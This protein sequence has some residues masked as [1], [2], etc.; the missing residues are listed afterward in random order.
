[1][2]LKIIFLSI[3]SFFYFSSKA[4]FSSNLPIVKLSISQ[5]IVDSYQQTSLDI[6]DNAS[7][8]NSTT[9]AATFTSNAGVR[10]RGNA[11][12]QAYPKK[13]YSLET[14]LGFNVSNNVPIL[15]MPAEND[16]VLLAAYPDRSLL[17]SKLMLE[18]HDEMDRYAPRMVYCE[19]LVNNVYQGIYLFGEKIKRDTSRLD[20]ANLKVT[21]NFG[22]ELTGGYILNVDDENGGG[23]NSNFQ[24][25]NAAASQQVKFLYEYPD[26]GDITPAQETYIQSYVD[27]FEKGLNGANFQ[28]SLLGWRA[29]GANNAFIDYI[30]INELTRNFDAYR[31]DMYLYKDKGTKLRPGPLWGGDATFA[32][33]A[34]CGANGITGFAYD[35][36]TACG[37]TANLPSFWWT[38]LMTDATFLADLKCRYTGYRYPGDV[39]DTAQM[40][41]LI[42][43]FAAQITANNAAM[44]NFAKYP[45]FGINIVNEPL[46]LAANYTEEVEKIKTFLRARI[47]WL[48]GRWLNTSCIPLSVN[49]WAKNNFSI[50]PNPATNQ[51]TISSPSASPLFYELRTMAGRIVQSGN[52]PLG[53]KTVVP[54]R[55]LPAGI[56]ILLLDQNEQRTMKKIVVE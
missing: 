45:I 8:L 49:N 27:S 29:Y 56:Y 42:D 15:G 43:T 52:N 16:W 19:L 38:K 3:L 12:T 28:D 35:I 13:S 47:A 37:T 24:P 41:S 21:D 40:F 31:I 51:I 46:P 6:I 20:I 22:I 32:N 14:W 4:Q 7:G 54:L 2:K 34:N 25:P 11:V 17:R 50:Y 33:T 9:D 30:I 39:L 55:K 36:G 23:F 1:M 48:D 44:R 18:L 10:L 53:E 26:N 5:P